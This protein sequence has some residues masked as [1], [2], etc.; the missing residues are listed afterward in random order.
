M[1]E[2]EEYI[3]TLSSYLHDNHTK[4]VSG[5]MWPKL[6]LLLSNLSCLTHFESRRV[7][8]GRSK[9]LSRIFRLLE[10]RYRSPT[11]GYISVYQTLYTIEIIHDSSACRIRS[12]S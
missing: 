11:K 7:L 8:I 9:I 4:L 1:R 3:S 5:F 12:L 2:I 6:A 10:C